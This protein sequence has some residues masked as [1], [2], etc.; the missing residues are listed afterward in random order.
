MVKDDKAGDLTGFK[1]SA[2]AQLIQLKAGA[3]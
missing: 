3:C 1:P 2:P